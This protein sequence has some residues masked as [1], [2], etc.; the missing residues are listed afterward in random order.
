MLLRNYCEDWRDKDSVTMDFKKQELEIKKALAEANNF[1][2][3]FKE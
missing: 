1:D 2:V 3:D